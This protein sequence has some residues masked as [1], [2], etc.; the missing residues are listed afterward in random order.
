LRL[1]LRGGKSNSYIIGVAWLLGCY[2]GTVYALHRGM[3]PNRIR[4]LKTN[5]AK[6][7]AFLSVY[8]A[9]REALSRAIIAAMPAGTYTTASLADAACGVYGV[10]AGISIT[11]RTCRGAAVAYPERVCATYT[12]GLDEIRITSKD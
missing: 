1:G 10:Q 5:A 11:E 4:S 3:T 12:L 7:R 8:R 9:E 2:A 6:D